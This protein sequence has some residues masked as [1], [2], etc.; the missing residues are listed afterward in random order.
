ME[1]LLK[2]VQRTNPSM[3]MDKLMEELKKSRSS[4]IGLILTMQF[5]KA[6]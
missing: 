4:A 3:T 2:F 1:G 6:E 5:C